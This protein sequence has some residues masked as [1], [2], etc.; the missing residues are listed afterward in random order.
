MGFTFADALK[1]LTDSVGSIGG[2]IDTAGKAYDQATRIGD[3]IKRRRVVSALGGL[4]Q[5][6]FSLNQRKLSAGTLIADY[7]DQPGYVSWS[8]VQEQ[9]RDISTVLQEV[10]RELEAQSSAS[11]SDIVVLSKLGGALASQA[12]FY[13]EL[14]KLDAP[15]SEAD[16]Q[17]AREI[18]GRLRVLLD[19]VLSLER[20]LLV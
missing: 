17:R 19:E 1:M 8:F 11:G 13:G 3:D 2:V 14:A 20:V 12:Y 6:M 7:L 15:A 18:S 10:Q 4:K 9:L 5:M 16:C